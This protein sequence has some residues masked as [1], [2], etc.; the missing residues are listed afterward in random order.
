MRGGQA[1]VKFGDF[2]QLRCHIATDSPSSTGIIM[3]L[4]FVL[5]LL[6]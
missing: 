3:Q 2:K 4:A 5:G 6:C 1:L